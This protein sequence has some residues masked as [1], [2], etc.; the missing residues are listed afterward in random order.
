MTTDLSCTTALHTAATQGHIDI[1]N[2]LLETDVN[3][4]KIARNNGKT[5]LHSAARM[6]HLEV[7]RSLLSKDPSTGFRTDKKGQ[8]ALHMAVKGQ[9][10]GIVQELVKPDPSVMNVEDNKGNTALH[11]AITKNRAQVLPPFFM[12]LL[13]SL[14]FRILYTL[15]TQSLQDIF[16]GKFCFS[17]A[18]LDGIYMLM[19]QLYE[20][21][22]MVGFLYKMITFRFVM[23]HSNYMLTMRRLSKVTLASFCIQITSRYNTMSVFL[24][25]YDQTPFLNY[26][27][28][29]NFVIHSCK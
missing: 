23:S 19:H 28:P 26:P 21:R 7:V 9:N 12:C 20:G 25:H 3:L 2:L 14:L 5:V 15:G 1:V 17:Y 13:S 29:S 22:N 4:V 10:E 8:T 27:F 6:G 16:L 24:V 11:I 18:F